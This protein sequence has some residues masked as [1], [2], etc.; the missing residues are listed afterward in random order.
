VSQLRTPV[1]LGTITK[2]EPAWSFCELA[3][4][5]GS[6]QK[7]DEIFVR[8]GPSLS[9]LISLKVSRLDGNRVIAEFD[10]LQP[11][12]KSLRPGNSIYTWKIL[13]K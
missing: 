4:P 3:C 13:S 10:S 5:S 9:N 7:G 11:I 12:T 8:S 1:Q 2:V 6:V